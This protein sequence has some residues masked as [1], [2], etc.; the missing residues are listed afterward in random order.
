MSFPGRNYFSVSKKI[1]PSMS[2]Q[3]SAANLLQS[4]LACPACRAGI[5]VAERQWSCVSCGSTGEIRDGV[6]LAKPLET[7]HYFDDMHQLM[8]EGNQTPAI[9]EMCYAQ[10]SHILSSMIRPG[11]VVVDIGCGPVIHFEKPA[12]CILIGVDPSFD[13]IRANAKLDI[14]VFG[15]AA[16]LPLRAASVDRISLFYS[17]HHMIG[18]TVAENR[19]NVT[20]ALRECG[21]VMRP[22]GTLAVFDMSPWWPVWQAQKL[23]WNKARKVLTDKLD[24]FFWRDSVLRGL[25]DSAFPGRKVETETFSISPFLVFPPVFSLPG[26]KLPRFLYPFDINMYKWSF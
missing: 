10:Q 15:S 19:D 17:I 25:A 9:R 7:A 5:R 23:T 20:A 4:Y 3:P 16:A 22:G 6:F 14:R 11:D 2:T 18:Q 26:L 1:R 13:S 21:R 24:M 12:D 8:Q